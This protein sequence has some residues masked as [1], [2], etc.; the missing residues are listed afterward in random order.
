MRPSDYELPVPSQASAIKAAWGSN[1]G[2]FAACSYQCNIKLSDQQK[3]LHV[4]LNKPIEV[5]N[6]LQHLLKAWVQPFLRHAVDPGW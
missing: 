5:L 3:L 4:I 1:P 6:D 2:V